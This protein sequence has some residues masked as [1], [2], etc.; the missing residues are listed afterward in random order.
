MKFISNYSISRRLI[1]AF[2]LA[3][4]L[5]SVMIAIM[6]IY[7]VNQLNS[8]R[9]ASSVIARAQ[10]STNSWA[11]NLDTMYTRTKNLESQVL[12]GLLEPIKMPST[13]EQ[14]LQDITRNSQQL[15]QDLATYQAQYDAMSPNMQP[16]INVL[17]S[18]VPNDSNPSADSTLL[19]EIVTGSWPEYQKSQADELKLLKQIVNTP[20]DPLNTNSIAAITHQLGAISTTLNLN[21]NHVNGDWEQ[22]GGYVS[23]ISRHI[24]G[25]DSNEMQPIIISTSG[26]FLLT[27]LVV[28]I[29]GILVYRSIFGPLNELVLLTRRIS[30]GDRHARARI[31][32]N[33]EISIVATAMNAMLD[34]IVRL[35]Q[36]TQAQRDVL[37]GQVE[38]L[39]SEVSG[40]GDGDLRINAEVTADALGVL[41]DS[42]NY[43]VEELGSLVIRVKQVARE[44]EKSTT[45]TSDHMNELVKT[46]DLQIQEITQA[47]FKVE[48]M[49][50]NS[51][52]VLSR[53]LV[54]T[55]S[56]R[57][58][59]I[60]AQGGRLAVQQT[61]EGMGRVYNNVQETSHKVQTLGERSREI[62]NIVE[63]ISNIAHQTNRLALDAAIQAAM[64]GENGKG[65]GA[66]AADIR[67]LAERA[68]E[69]A[70]SV[71]RIVRSVGDDIKAVAMSM[72]DTE[73]ETSAGSKLAEEAGTSLESIVAVIERQA[74]EIESI[75]QMAIQ[76]QQSSSEVVQ[77]MQN[78]SET[79][80]QSTNSTRDVAQ[81][82]ERAARLAEQLLASVEAFKLREDLGQPELSH[83]PF[84][85]RENM[86]L[87]N[88]RTASGRFRTI[89]STAQPIS[90]GG[91]PYTP[92]TPGVQGFPSP[93]SQF[94]LPSYPPSNGKNH[95]SSPLLPQQDYTGNAGDQQPFPGWN[96]GANQQSFPAPE[97]RN[98][99][100]G[101]PPAPYNWQPENWN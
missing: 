21:Y 3:A 85:S 35:V 26:A 59:R 43:M 22:L 86:D 51:Q 38:K 56:A 97:Q 16:V 93:I 49:A 41:A 28:S 20:P 55:N 5:P 31:S 11:S 17:N 88:P 10:D 65:F 58:A 12:L 60:S 94:I 18:A 71:G 32:S 45:M 101:M 1:V 61:I 4:I 48:Q 40:V 24:N 83:D 23:N 84:S 8:R 63:A 73:R 30:Q 19:H 9:D 74:N 68:K 7:Y 100:P 90:N 33:D 70:A 89:T 42:F 75:N 80:Q 52:Q 96:N 53:A 54:L 2:A 47:A 95:N 76:Q 66:V 36:D 64:A 6:G 69:Q 67:R 91:I 25:V 13:A 77:V 14:A 92:P 99:A 98:Q 57:E 34:N 39:V 29:A 72:N 15:A 44:V 50:V 78:V 79:T 82:M 81:N 27:L 62:N 37:Q 46:A 87:D